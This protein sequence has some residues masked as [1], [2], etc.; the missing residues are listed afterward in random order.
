[1]NVS[2]ICLS[3]THYFGQNAFENRFSLN[4]SY[5]WLKNPFQAPIKSNA[6]I[7]L[8]VIFFKMKSNLNTTAEPS[9]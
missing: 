5:Q 2:F 7:F 6:F 1:M 8:Q 4:I 9:K 3:I